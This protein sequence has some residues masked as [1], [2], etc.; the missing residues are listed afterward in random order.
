MHVSTSDRGRFAGLV[1]AAGLMLPTI[2]TLLTEALVYPEITRPNAVGDALYLS[3]LVL[4]L[5]LTIGAVWNA[6]IERVWRAVGMVFALTAYFAAIIVGAVVGM[7][8]F[9]LPVD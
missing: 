8:V 7:M 5:L 9:R 3:L 4:G 6:P 2:A 1:G